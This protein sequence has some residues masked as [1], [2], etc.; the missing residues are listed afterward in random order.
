MF[1]MEELKLL[2]LYVPEFDKMN[3]QVSSVSVGWHLEHSL[4]V[5]N[6]V[7]EN[8]KQS[9]PLEYRRRINL[10]WIYIVL[11]GGIPRGRGKSPKIV[12]PEGVISRDRLKANL[13]KCQHQIEL[14][15]SFHNNCHF[16]H[17]YF[18]IL[19]VKSTK[20]FLKIHTRHHLSIISDV[21]KE[22]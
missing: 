6:V 20:K 4:K 14:L 2:A 10:S 11:R 8:L 15:E 3:E 16:A 22:N 17:P 18:G 9:D 12:K 13:L 1:L 7:V 21:L 19:N 5:I